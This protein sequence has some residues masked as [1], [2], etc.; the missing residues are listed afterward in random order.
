MLLVEMGSNPSVPLP[1]K[2]LCRSRVPW[3]EW[4]TQA[5]AACFKLR[6]NDR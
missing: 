2:R 6:S 1:V 3:I 5:H 4:R